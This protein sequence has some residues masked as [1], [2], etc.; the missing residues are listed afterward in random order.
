LLSAAGRFVPE[1]L[2]LGRDSGGE[3]LGVQKIH[4]LLLAVA[5][6]RIVI[7]LILG[8]AGAS[9]AGMQL[10]YYLEASPYARM[11]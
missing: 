2:A 8:D 3:S 7:V 4:V 11:L 5:A 6:A 9:E 10:E 1:R